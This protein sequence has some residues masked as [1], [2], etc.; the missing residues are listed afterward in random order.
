MAMVEAAAL[1]VSEAADELGL[2]GADV[3]EL[4]FTQALAFTQAANGRI[5]VPRQALDDFRARAAS[6]TPTPS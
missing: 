5:L 1:T 6:E 4:I 3:Y 2:D